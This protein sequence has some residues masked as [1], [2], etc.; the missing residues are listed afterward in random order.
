ME[1]REEQSNEKIKDIK[2]IQNF[3]NSYGVNIECKEIHYSTNSTTYIVDLMD[4]VRV[5]DVEKLKL[6]IQMV[7]GAI[8]V[9][10]R[11]S[12]NRTTYLGIILIKE[13]RNILKL[14]TLINSSEFQE[15]NKSIPIIL[16]RDYS[17]E[18]I[19][20]DLSEIH[21]ML[22]AGTVGT[23][24]SVFLSTI[25]LEIIKKKNPNEVKLLLIDTRGTN[26]TQFNGIPH[27]LIPTVTETN[28]A[29]L[30]LTW[31][32]QKMKDRYKLFSEKSVDNIV[33]Y[34]KIS[35]EKLCNIVIVIEDFGDLMDN[36]KEVEEYTKAIIQMSRAAGIYLIISTQRPSVD[37]ITG[38]IKANILTKI[39]F[40]VP[41]QVDSRVILDRAGAEKL[42]DYGDALFIKNGFD[43]P[44]R[45]ETPYVSDNEIKNA[46]LEVSKNS[47]NQYQE[48]IMNFIKNKNNILSENDKEDSLLND[49]IE[50]VIET[51]QASTSFIQ[52]R[53]KIDYARAGRIIDDME[54]RGI[55]SGYMGSK[56][57]EILMTKERWTELNSIEQNKYQ[58]YDSYKSKGKK[59]DIDEDEEKKKKVNNVFMIM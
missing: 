27:L 8:D 19:V 41:A 48:D 7:F 50:V 30:A 18:V 9:F 54:E 40:K 49:A 45:M 39:A 58:N 33:S 55:I 4:G 59:E 28:Q 11:K 47:E 22:I 25:I 23:G 14:D 36:S 56:P 29:I 5:K 38:T 10:F 32:Y 17:G 42:L 1:S 51:G 16:G 12:I 44:L 15:N 46:V 34:N 20:E 43:E 57:R 2:K 21:H 53:F 31:S 13:K 6:E 37:V 26:F 24:K 3:F 35:Q 52:R